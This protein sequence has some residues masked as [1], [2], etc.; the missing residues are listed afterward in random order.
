[1]RPW[2]WGVPLS[3]L[4]PEALIVYPAD[5]CEIDILSDDGTRELQGVACKKLPP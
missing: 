1:M 4:Q 3:G 5:P 2:K